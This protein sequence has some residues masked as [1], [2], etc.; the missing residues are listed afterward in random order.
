MPIVVPHLDLSVLARNNGQTPDQ[1]ERS[2]PFKK[3]A[4]VSTPNV[5]ARRFEDNEAHLSGRRS[6]KSVCYDDVDLIQLR[7]PNQF[8]RNSFLNVSAPNMDSKQAPDGVN[9]ALDDSRSIEWMK[10][11]PNDE[12]QQVDTVSDESSKKGL[13]VYHDS[14]SQV[15]REWA[16]MRDQARK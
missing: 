14:E 13:G 10:A 2:N 8:I 6:N 7:E 15:E 11:F 16:Q 9:Q 5:K 1:R 3:A 12:F 4:N